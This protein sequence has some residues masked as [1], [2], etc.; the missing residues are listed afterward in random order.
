MIKLEIKNR[1]KREDFDLFIDH[2][3][4]F[5]LYKKKL[6]SICYPN[7]NFLIA[8]PPVGWLRAETVRNKYYFDEIFFHLHLYIGKIITK[9]RLDHLF[10]C[11]R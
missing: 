5:P 3:I 6:Y 10:S 4:E 11:N 7:G 9:S 2:Y 1:R 8:E